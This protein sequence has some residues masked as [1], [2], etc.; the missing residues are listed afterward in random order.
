MTVDSVH[1]RE[2]VSPRDRKHV[3][4][5]V[6]ATG[7]FSPDEIDVA[8][9]LVDERLNKGLESGYEFL[10]AE[11]DGRPV[12][13][14][15]F[16]PIA[17]TRSSWDLYWIA[18]CPEEQGTGIGKLLLHKSEE[19]IRARGGSRVYVETSSRDQYAPTRAFYERAGYDKE[20]E[21]VDFYA[22]GDAKVIYSKSLE[23]VE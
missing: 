1:L 12:G 14:A 15:C 6:E 17:C 10:F 23:F 4:D 21:L 2:E 19:A 5:I 11:R 13:Y 16:G 18:V 20:A 9:E 22:P 8:V 7:F 3:R